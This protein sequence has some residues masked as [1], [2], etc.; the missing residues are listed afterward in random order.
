ME[1]RVLERE[2]EGYEGVSFEYK[3]RE[4]GGK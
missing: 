2:S 1:A 3:E 4:F